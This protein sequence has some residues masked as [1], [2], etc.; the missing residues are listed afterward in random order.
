[1]FKNL[2]SKILKLSLEVNIVNTVR[3]HKYDWFFYPLD[4]NNNPL[5][6]ETN[7]KLR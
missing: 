1:M 6:A 3:S 7:E 4:K 5:E 2:F